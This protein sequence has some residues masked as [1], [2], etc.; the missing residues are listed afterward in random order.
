LLF[1]AYSNPPFRTIRLRPRKPKCASCSAQATVTRTALSSGSLDYVQ[2]CGAVSPINA[3]SPSERISAENYARIRTG[4]NPITGTEARTD[5]HVL[6]D[7]REKVQFNLCNLE[8]SINIPYS[9]V[10]GTSTSIA[11]G[12][13]TPPEQ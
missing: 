10:S 8:G 11:S 7:V 13:Q 12:V 6:I 4:A 2:F 5:N 3:L 9:V 1:S